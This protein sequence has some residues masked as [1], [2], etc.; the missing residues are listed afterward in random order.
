VVDNSVLGLAA[1]VILA[2]GSIA[3]YVSYQ[4]GFDAYLVELHWTGRQTDWGATKDRYDRLSL[5]DIRIN[6]VSFSEL[7]QYLDR[8]TP[9]VYCDPEAQVIWA[10]RDVS[11]GRVD[12]RVYVHNDLDS[13]VD[14]VRDAVNI[15][16]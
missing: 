7:K 3:G 8:Y 12:V 10:Y 16:G 13:V 2:G 5:L 9:S 4:D 1:L 14:Y 11:P 15:I 6:Y